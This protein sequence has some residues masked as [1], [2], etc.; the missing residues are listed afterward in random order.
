MRI[1]EWMDVERGL[2]CATG[3]NMRPKL[4]QSGLEM[5][6]PSVPDIAEL[7]CYRYLVARSVDPRSDRLNRR[8]ALTWEIVKRDL[9]SHL[10]SSIRS[11]GQARN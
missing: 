2:V 11:S 7:Q 5:Y 8:P 6:V 9:A 10:V 3:K 4:K 1:G